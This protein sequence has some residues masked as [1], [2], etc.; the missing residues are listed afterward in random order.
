MKTCT[1]E[2]NNVVAKFLLLNL[3]IATS[4]TVEQQPKTLKLLQHILI[5]FVC[6]GFCVDEVFRFCQCFT[7]YL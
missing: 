4:Y 2:F 5:R 7:I 3:I 6:C 1:L